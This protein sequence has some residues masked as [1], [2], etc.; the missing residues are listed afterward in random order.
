MQ[1]ADNYLHY[2]F[3]K[4]PLIMIASLV[5][6]KFNFSHLVTDEYE[7]N[8]Q[9]TQ[10]ELHR[11]FHSLGAGII[12][13][14]RVQPDK[15]FGFVRYNNHAEAALAIQMGNT[16]SILYGKQIK[17]RM[18]LYRFS[19][20]SLLN[21]WQ[22]TSFNHMWC[23]KYIQLD[24]FIYLFIFWSDS[25]LIFSCVLFSSVSLMLYISI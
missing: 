9:V 15:G 10:L 24:F 20:R 1:L 22:L 11:H 5:K 19:P 12:E 16:Q 3:A 2:L 14:V 6:F 4:H 23:G 25:L 7:L 17:V 18:Y 21:R 8:Y 13:E